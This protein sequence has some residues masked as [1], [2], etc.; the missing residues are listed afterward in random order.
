MTIL[1]PVDFSE[2]TT[3]VLGY[4]SVL[5]AA[6]SGQLYLLHVTAPD[7]EFVGYAAGPQTVRDQVAR[8]YREVHQRLQAEAEALRESGLDAIAILAQG[9]SV[10]TILK[11][12]GRLG[13]D[14][15]VMGSHGHGAVHHLLVGSVSQ[16]VLKKSPCP[17]MVVPSPARDEGD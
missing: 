4:A 8:R 17:V 16:G 11:E 2:V 3:R 9:P 6:L 10:E 1:V 7:P 14:L 15:I 13:V 5:G 12:A